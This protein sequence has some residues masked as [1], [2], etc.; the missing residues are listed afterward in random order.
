MHISIQKEKSIHLRVTKHLRRSK[1]TLFQLL[2]T[3]ICGPKIPFMN[4]RKFNQIK[5]G[6]IRLWHYCIIVFLSLLPATVLS[7]NLYDTIALIP[8]TP[9]KD[10]Q[11]SS[12]CWSFA[13]TSFIESELIRNGI[14][15]PDLS[16]MY[17]AYHA[18]QAK[19]VMHVRMQGNNFFTPGGQ[20]H[21]VMNVVR[22]YG[23]MTENA[24]G[25]YTNGSGGHNQ[26]L[27]DTALIRYMRQIAQ[28]KS[29]ALPGNWSLVVDSIISVHLGTPP[30]K[31][32]YNDKTCSA[33][34]FRDSLDFDPDNYITI[35]SY[36]HHP[37][38]TWFVLEDRFNWAMGEYYNVP[39][40]VFEMICDS[41]LLK[42]YS[43]VWDGDVSEKTFN[44]ESGMAIL[45]LKP[46]DDT[47][48]IR[49]R[50]FDTHET[51]VDHVMHIVGKLKKYNGD[52]YYLIKNSWGEYGRNKGYICM[53]QG[54][55]IL[56]TV[57]IMVNKNTL[58]E[59]LKKMF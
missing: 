46:G 29:P 28:L 41:A 1:R 55:F 2:L 19:T 14:T 8:H 43:V 38:Y 34:D 54:Y 16:E 49:Q 27:L 53:N 51:T 13:T 33:A 37:Y 59:E 23:M 10:Q 9:I 52:T 17:F 42:G 50:M 3:L 30:E 25:G 45:Q 31:F 56:K 48:A 6:L 5:S 58:P 22:H 18:L 11:M 26:A 32:Q 44:A 36:S 20:M 35:T 40:D 12:T 57:A 39:P 24:Y 4:I 21:D 7:Q 47:T 15:D